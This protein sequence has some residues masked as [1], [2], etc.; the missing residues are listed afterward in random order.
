HQID[1][2]QAL[3]RIKT[4]RSKKQIDLIRS[5]VFTGE[6][7]TADKKALPFVVFA[8]A[9]TQAV[10]VKKDNKTYQSHRLDESVVEHSGL[11]VLDFDKI[12][13]SQKIEQLKKDPYIFACWVG[14]SGTGVKALVKCPPSIEN[15]DLYYTA[16]LDRYPELDS[17]S[18]NISRG[19]FES[20]DPDIWINKSSL[21]WDKRMTQEQ[22]KKNK[23]KE[24]NKR[25]V[26]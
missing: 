16:F 17:T 25:S 5:K 7:Y 23:E 22:H 21:V 14:P 6:D 11:F 12:D 10:E 13:V 3:K 1:I 8:A 24:K 18:R 9:A 26:R 15:H 4:G 2:F 19:T 20:F